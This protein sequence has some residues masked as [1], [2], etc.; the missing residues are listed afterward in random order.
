MDDIAYIT[1]A[2]RANEEE[3]VKA[4]QQVVGHLQWGGYTVI[5]GGATNEE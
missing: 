4:L 1:V 5:A 3:A 2:I